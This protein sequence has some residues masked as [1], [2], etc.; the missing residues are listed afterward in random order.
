[1]IRPSFSTNFG[2]LNFVF[3]QGEG[4]F[5]WQFTTVEQFS[6]TSL[7]LSLRSLEA[8]EVELHDLTERLQ[9]VSSHNVPGM[10]ELKPGKTF[11]AL[12]SWKLGNLGKI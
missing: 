10:A 8:L 5:F 9:K 12:D 6:G 11:G 7:A 1:M 4:Q 2:K 3:F